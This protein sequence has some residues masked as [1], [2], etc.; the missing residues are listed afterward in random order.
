MGADPKAPGGCCTHRRRWRTAPTRASGCE[1]RPVYVPKVL[2]PLP[3]DDRKRLLRAARVNTYQRREILVHEGA[4]SDDFHI[5]LEGR[6][7]IRVHT[8]SGDSAIV[9]ILGP[10]DHFG[11]VSLLAESPD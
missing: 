4:A 8:S 3:D 1:T 5:L 2:R 6:V 7:A 9:N 11:E 10:D